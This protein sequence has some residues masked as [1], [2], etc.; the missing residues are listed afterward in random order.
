MHAHLFIAKLLKTFSIKIIRHVFKWNVEKGTTLTASKI[1]DKCPTQRFSDK[2]LTEGM[3]KTTND[4]A[5][6][7]GMGTLGVDW[8]I[9]VNVIYFLPSP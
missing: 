1:I 4:Q 7:G 3:D 9:K 5:G 6:G 8:A 2:F